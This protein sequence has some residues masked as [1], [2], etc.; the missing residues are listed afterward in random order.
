LVMGSPR[1]RDIFVTEV[2]IPQSEEEAKY[3]AAK[4]GARPILGAAANS[5]TFIKNAPESDLIYLAAH[6]IAGSGS[7][8]DPL[9]DSY[10]VLSDTRMAASTIKEFGEN[11]L[12]ARLVVLSA[13][14][15]GLGRVTEAG[16]VGL[17]RT[18]LDAGAGNVVMSNWNIDDDATRI[19][20]EYFIDALDNNQPSEALRL[21]Q[22]KLIEKYP[23]PALWASFNVFGNHFTAIH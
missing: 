8:A 15:T 22:L 6:G 2:P 10:I 1:G 12:K 9:R 23:D 4:F 3:V 5:I 7:R 14:Q 19:L 20:M 16:V 17:A 11:G 21:A 18:F 13:C